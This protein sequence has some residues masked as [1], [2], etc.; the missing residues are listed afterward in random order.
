M[1]GMLGI[2]FGMLDTLPL[3]SPFLGGG[4][5]VSV[6]PVVAGPLVPRPKEL[7]VCSL[8]IAFFFSSSK[9]SYH[10]VEMGVSNSSEFPCSFII[11]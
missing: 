11:Y 2:S 1:V 4:W 3:T 6:Q 7:T 5:V 10:Y 9:C 8:F